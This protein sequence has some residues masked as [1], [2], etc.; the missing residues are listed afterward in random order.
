MSAETTIS[1]LHAENIR[2]EEEALEKNAL[3]IAMKVELQN[4]LNELSDYNHGD[5]KSY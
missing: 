1:K 4:A 3:F 2:L 5:H